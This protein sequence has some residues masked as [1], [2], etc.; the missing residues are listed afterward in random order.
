MT[1]SGSGSFTAPGLFF[2]QF[3]KALSNNVSNIATNLLT[4]C[5]DMRYKQFIKAV[6]EEAFADLNREISTTAETGDG[7]CHVNCNAVRV[8]SWT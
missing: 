2:C 4:A 5:S 8:S 6:H 3:S 1:K 7:G